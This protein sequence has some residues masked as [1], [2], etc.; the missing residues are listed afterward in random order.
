MT[1]RVRNLVLGDKDVVFLTDGRIENGCATGITARNLLTAIGLP[2]DIKAIAE[3][4]ALTAPVNL[5]AIALKFIT[6]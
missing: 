6:R 1:V 4:R 3:I 5:T 2:L